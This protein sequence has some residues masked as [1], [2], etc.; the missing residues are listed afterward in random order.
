MTQA[1]DE[2]S[3]R[4]KAYL[5]SAKAYKPLLNFIQAQPESD[6]RD[7]A[8]IYFRIA[9]DYDVRDERSLK[10][11]NDLAARLLAIADVYFALRFEVLVNQKNTP[12]GK[13]YVA[14]DSASQGRLSVLV[15]R[16]KAQL[17]FAQRD[18]LR[19]F[20]DY[21]GAA[22]PDPKRLEKFLEYYKFA[23]LQDS[24]LAYIEVSQ[25]Y[26]DTDK[27]SLTVFYAVSFMTLSKKDCDSDFAARYEKNVKADG[28]VWKRRYDA[29]E[30][31]QREKL[32]QAYKEKQTIQ[33]T[34]EYT[35]KDKKVYP[36]TEKL[37]IPNT[38]P[39]LRADPDDQRPIPPASATQR[40]FLRRF[41]AYMNARDKKAT[42]DFT[43]Y[44]QARSAQELQECLDVYLQASKPYGDHD[45]F[46]LS[47]FFGVAALAVA[48]SDGYFAFKLKSAIQAEGTLAAR[49]Y[50]ALNAWQKG[51]LNK[52]ITK[53]EKYH[54]LI[55][56]IKIAYYQQNHKDPDLDSL[57]NFVMP[58]GEEQ[59]RALSAL[60]G[61]CDV[62]FT[63][64]HIDDFMAAF[65]ALSDA[66][67]AQKDLMVLY[68]MFQYCRRSVGLSATVRYQ[69]SW[70]LA[71]ALFV[72]ALPQRPEVYQRGLS[73]EELVLLFDASDR[74]NP[75]F[76]DFAL[77]MDYLWLHRQNHTQ[78]TQLS[79]A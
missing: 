45:E 36:V 35:S 29:L 50:N 16:K 7:C 39:S 13:H 49:R 59:A 40:E 25:K 23:Q 28:T 70:Y 24:L 11:Y 10:T 4:F 32:Q 61:R 30:W 1:Q 47:I 72:Q 31:W 76:N 9:A 68:R 51:E 71:G 14:L 42:Q 66:V 17:S 65:D 74:R 20:E 43:E 52:E 53:K 44:L 67:H 57:R 22:H 69:L 46:S 34:T 2:F 78:F 18:F 56:D 5:A 75:Y 48:R 33:R 77:R 6:L 54:R 63:T 79:K 15:K 55:D 27:N 38:A 3:T 12:W 26:A 58:L 21:V 19:I 41:K 8:T 64:H 73:D 60:L 37:A 62:T